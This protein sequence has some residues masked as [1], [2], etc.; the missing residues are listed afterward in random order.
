MGEK[1]RE[2]A[3]VLAVAPDDEKYDFA[4]NFRVCEFNMDKNYQYVKKDFV[5]TLISNILYYGIAIPILSIIIK[6]IYNLKIEGK[7]NIEKIENGAISV[8]NHVLVL[9]CAMVGLAFGRKKKIFYTTQE[10]SFKIP[11]VRK[12]I[13]LLRAVPI[14]K[15]I[16]N[17][18][19]FIKETNNLLKNGNIVHFYPEGVLKPYCEEIRNFKN[20]AF[21]FAIK[22]NV[23]IVPMVFVFKNPT[24]IRK[25]FKIKK[26]VILKI[27][28]PIKCDNIEIENLNV[29]KTKVQD[30]MRKEI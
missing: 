28:E 21:N 22:N 6:L 27:L 1:L 25:I 9:D 8:S 11:F 3:E 17:Q 23:Q 14:P 20:G 13:K 24:G 19:N 2:D 26:D 4:A 29:L 12:L 16:E 30:V 7:E 5:F 15:K 10:E 18:K